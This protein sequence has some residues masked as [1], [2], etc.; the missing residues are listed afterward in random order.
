MQRLLKTSAS[1][2]VVRMCIKNGRQII[3]I[4]TKKL[5]L[6]AQL[7]QIAIPGDVIVVKDSSFDLYYFY[8][9]EDEVAAFTELGVL[10][11]SLSRAVGSSRMV[12]IW[13]CC[14]NWK[15][16][17]RIESVLRAKDEIEGRTKLFFP[18]SYQ[19]LRKNSESFCF[20]CV[21]RKSITL[22][23]V[24]GLNY[25]ILPTQATSGAALAGMGIGFTLGLLGGPLAPV[26]IPVGVG[27]G[28]A[29]GA[30]VGL[31]TSLTNGAITHLRK[32]SRLKC[33]CSEKTTNQCKS[34]G[35]VNCEKLVVLRSPS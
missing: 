32:W 8:V 33:Y 10:A 9:S 18:G 26:S 3:F 17:C 21:H 4:K 7:L 23:G 1:Q 31:L 27:F 5:S 15:C 12:T 30:G 29:I 34:I 22:R 35:V 13:R 19:L 28:T 25:L 6:T 24:K 16:R 14:D 2:A 11:V 20:Y